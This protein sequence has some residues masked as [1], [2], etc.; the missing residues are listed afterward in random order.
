MTISEAVLTDAT[1]VGTLVL[2]DALIGMT[3][4]D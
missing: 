2:E 1:A 4:S 3:L